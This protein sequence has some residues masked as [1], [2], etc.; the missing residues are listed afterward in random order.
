MHWG[1]KRGSTDQHQ[2]FQKP[3]NENEAQ[4]FGKPPTNPASPQF[5]VGLTADE[6]KLYSQLF[7]ALDPE[8]TGIITGEKARA[9][10]EKSGLPPP[11]LGEIWQL[12]DQN[13]LGFL[14]QFGFCFAMRLI[15]YT[16]LGQLPSAALAETPG[17]LPR[18]ANLS[19]PAPLQPQST[20]S[21]FMQSQPSAYVPHDT[22]SVPQ[23]NLTAVSSADVQKFLQLFTKTVGSPS[24]ELSGTRARDIFMKSK[25]PTPTL[26]QIWV[27]VDRK[28]LGKLDMPS[29]VIAMHLIQGLLSGSIKQLPPFLPETVWQSVEQSTLQS[30]QL[31]QPLEAPAQPGSRQPS[32]ASVSSQQT[33]VRHDNRAPSGSLQPSASTQGS[34]WVV[35]PTMKAQYD[36]IFN[37]IDKS[38]SGQLS[39]DQVATFLMTSKLGQQDLASIWDLADVQNTGIFTP[40]EFAIALFLVNKKLAG[41]DLPHIVP[42]S[43]I[44]SI[45]DAK[46]TAPSA[47]KPSQLAP[48]QSLAPQP[49]APAQP[50]QPLQ[51]QKTAMDD[52]V[53]IFG[54]PTKPGTESNATPSPSTNFSEAPRTT[55]GELPR[56]RGL[57]P[58]K[59]SSSFGQGL[60]KAQSPVL[61]ID[62]SRDV[63]HSSQNSA[64]VQKPDAIPGL[65]QKPTPTAAQ[66]NIQPQSLGLLLAHAVNYDALRS[67]P[68]PPRTL[69][70]LTPLSPGH[71]TLQNRD[72]LADTSSPVSGELSRATTDIANVS[73]QIKSLASQTS[74]LHETKSRAEQELTRILT[75]KK[76]I[77]SKLR[78]LRSSYENEVKQKEEVEANLAAA[79]EETEALRSEASIS[80]AK[81][82]HISSELN[83]KQMEMEELQKQNSTLKERLGETNAE[84][85][86]LEKQYERTTAENQ[87][88]TNQVSVK[89]SQLQVSIVKS[90]NLKRT[91]EELT[92]ANRQMAEELS[93]FEAR[94]KQEAE[95]QKRLQ[96][97]HEQAQKQHEAN[98]KAL[99]DKKESSSGS[100]LALGI[101]AGVG[102][103]VGAAIAG[104]AGL[105]KSVAGGSDDVAPSEKEGD[106]S[107][108]EVP[109]K[110]V[111]NANVSDSQNAFVSTT[112]ESTAPARL[113]TSADLEG[114]AEPSSVEPSVGGPSSVATNTYNDF[115]PVTSPSNS[116][117]QFPEGAN[118]GIATGVPGMPG[119]FHGVQR[120]D[121][122][123]SSVQNNAAMSVRDDNIDV[124]DRDTIS[125]S[126]EDATT[127]A[128]AETIAPQ[129]RNAEN[130]SSDA[131]K[132]SS[133]VGSFEIVNAEDSEQVEQ[134]EASQPGSSHREAF[135][136]SNPSL[137]HQQRSPDI[138]SE[139]PPIRELDYDESSSDDGSQHFDDALSEQARERSKEPRDDFDASFAGL[140]PA[141]EEKAVNSN[142]PFDEFDGLEAAREEEAIGDDDFEGP[143]EFGEFTQSS[144]GALFDNNGA[145]ESDEKSGNDEWEQLFAGFGN[146]QQ[147]PQQALQQALQSVPN[148][149]D[150][151]RE[152][153]V[154]EL[155]GMGFDDKTSREALENENWNL[156]AATNYLLDHA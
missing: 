65:P 152:A 58:F 110:E 68:P 99:S 136:I 151:D 149:L 71:S 22:Q 8:N 21:S 29:F 43:L 128:D 106:K 57:Q 82:N 118:A 137:E 1:N 155:V 5:K 36:S 129:L 139:F 132:V 15:G 18:F 78:Q 2:H 33:T 122:L 131:D 42:Q 46:N 113:V 27:L 41:E 105:A 51:T 54:S 50:P 116:D 63:S 11:I 140:E 60:V 80:E 19:T 47:S 98:S 25:L 138:N 144:H 81:F 26:G 97:E 87:R 88:L 59:P 111:S 39:P 108:S 75:S 134:S 107:V 79:K 28:N 37:N 130:D 114:S 61:E 38:H 76:E 117:F 17:P 31:H 150:K 56:V 13:N 83:A 34:D 103:G 104:A 53:D 109:E 133:G 115:T 124:S 121:S 93:T 135:I 96:H 10:F 153:A 141:V 3:L 147:P 44:Q 89:R 101:G 90:E 112:T 85:V 4:N 64:S 145:G 66:A 72:L 48:T 9:T 86:E 40:T 24:G 52:L 142:D 84:I 55:T 123:T 70:Q 125:A 127:Q 143:P 30:S 156:E 73:N 74:D 6:K 92:L 49:L 14:T 67:V 12:A 7:R 146:A 154:Q 126:H 45:E 102:A 119:D 95:Q 23:E 32:Y 91:I 77:E 100:G 35:T 62:E 120:T 69:S 20:N 16:Q 94:E 148:G